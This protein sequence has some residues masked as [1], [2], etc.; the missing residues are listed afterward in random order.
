MHARLSFYSCEDPPEVEL[1]LGNGDPYSDGYWSHTFA[2]R[3]EEATCDMQVSYTSADRIQATFSRN[4][5]HINF[6]VFKI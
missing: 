2:V 1:S 4:A 5:S 6:Q 3:A